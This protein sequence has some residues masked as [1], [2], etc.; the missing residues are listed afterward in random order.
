[1]RGDVRGDEAA[2][3]EHV[4]IEKQHQAGFRSAITGITSRRRSPILL[5]DDAKTASWPQLAQHIGYAVG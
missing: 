3:A 1:M 4:V 2:V 5:L